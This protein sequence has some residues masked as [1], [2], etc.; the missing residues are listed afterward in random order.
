MLPTKLLSPTTQTTQLSMADET[1]YYCS[2]LDS[3]WPPIIQKWVFGFPCHESKK[4]EVSTT[5][6]AG[7]VSTLRQRPYL[8]G[9]ITA[10]ESI[11]AGPRTGRLKITYTNGGEQC[12]YEEKA[13]QVLSVEDLSDKPELWSYS[14]DD[15]RAL[16]MQPGALGGKQLWPQ[17]GNERL[18]S[19]VFAV[20]A[21][22]ISGGLL[23]CVCLHHAFTDG[24]GAP[25]ILGDWAENCSKYQNHRQD[26]TAF[27]SAASS[28]PLPALFSDT[29]SPQPLVLPSELADDKAPRPGPEVDRLASRASL[30]KDLGLIQPALQGVPAPKPS[31]AWPTSAVR[32]PD[33][34]TI[35]SAIFFASEA[36]ISSLKADLSS[37]SRISSIDATLALLW[38]CIIRA[39]LPDLPQPV[40]P[41]PVSRLRVPTNVRQTLGLPAQYLGNAFLNSVTE[42]PLDLLLS[43]SEPAKHNIAPRIRTSFLAARDPGGARDAIA[44]SFA[45]PQLLGP[46]RGRRAQQAIFAAG[47][48]GGPPNGLDLVVSSWRDMDMYRHRWGP[49]FGM[50]QEMPEFVLPPVGSSYL[51]GLCGILP[52]RFHSKG[53]GA[54][55]SS[56]SDVEV[57]VSLPGKQMERLKSDTEF[58][59]YFKD[60]E[61]Q[62]KDLMG[63]ARL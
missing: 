12:F 22:I 2:T 39:R 48:D 31:G 5:L 23:L 3:I 37:A 9:R 44:L 43:S 28:R 45:I 49:V 61:A 36:A 38:R 41:S 7:L 56:T 10:E 50:S 47:A 21:N 29:P 58:M 35:V 63:K 42:L 57:I 62:A 25:I 60:T 20:K 55:A 4:A 19:A 14:Y 52:R 17:G 34:E 40:K 18:A 54:S 33:P 59:M 6:F 16:G 51:P 32:A 46:E 13:R 11:K 1:T 30:W 26:N 27:S 53:E 8:S 15:L 24:A